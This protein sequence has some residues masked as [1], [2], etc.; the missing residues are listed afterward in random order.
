LL[1]CPYSW[2]YSE[3]TTGKNLKIA[4]PHNHDS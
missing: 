2:P 4:G 3:G 1:F